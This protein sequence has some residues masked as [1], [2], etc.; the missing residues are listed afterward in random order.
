MKKKKYSDDEVTKKARA[1]IDAMPEWQ[2]DYAEGMIEM[3]ILGSD[4][5]LPNMLGKLKEK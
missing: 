5:D 3:A 2:I 1:I 4:N